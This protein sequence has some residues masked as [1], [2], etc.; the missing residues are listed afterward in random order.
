MR[1]REFLGLASGALVAWPCSGSAQQA[2]RKPTIGVLWHAANEEEEGPYF[3]AL[4]Q[5]FGS[6]GYVDGRN[7]TLI[8]RFAN[9]TPERFKM[10]AAELVS[11]RVDVLVSV[12]AAT[13][14]YV[15]NAN[16]NIPFVFT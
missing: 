15:K 13:A 5:G 11:L 6:L 9:E 12:G 7:I 4:I 8:H 3:K 16:T 1:R 14:P 10:L 2:G